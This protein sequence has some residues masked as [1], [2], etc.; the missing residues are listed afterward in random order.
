MA[1][2]RTLDKSLPDGSSLLL[3]KRRIVQCQL[4]ARLERL[5]EGWEAFIQ[6]LDGFDEDAVDVEN[7]MGSLDVL[8]REKL[9]GRIQ[10]RSKLHKATP[11]NVLQ[12]VIELRRHFNHILEV[13]M[14]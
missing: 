1:T 3:T 12:V 5:I 14:V 13:V 4:D 7:L 9:N 11:V 2:S 6:R 10:W 8:Q